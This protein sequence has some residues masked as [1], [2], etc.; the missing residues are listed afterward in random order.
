M[1]NVS[2]LLALLLAL[3]LIVGCGATTSSVENTSAEESVAA[4]PPVEETPAEEVPAEEPP[5][6]AQS[7]VEAPAPETDVPTEEPANE[8]FTPVAYSFPL[9]EESQTLTYFTTISPNNTSFM[10]NYSVNESV[11]VLEELTGVHIEY[12]CY[13]PENA[14][15]QF[16][17]QAAAGSLPDIILGATEYYSGGM[18]TAVDDDILLNLADYL[19][20]APNYSQI[21]DLTPDMRSSLSTEVGNL[22]GFY[23]YSDPAIATPVSASMMI[24][25]DWLEQVGMEAP[26]TYDELHDVLVA[27]KNEMSVEYPMIVTSYLDDMGGSFASGYDIKAFFMTS[28]GIQV[29]FY[30]IDGQVKCAIVEDAFV[31][32]IKMIQGLVAEGLVDPNVESY[33]NERSYQDKVLAGETGVFWGFGIR[34]M[35]TLNSQMD[36]Y[37][38]AVPAMRK[39][40]DQT[41]HFT[42]DA[43]YEV[44]SAVSLSANCSDIELACKWLDAH[45]TEEI[46]MMAMYGV[47]GVSY[48][49]VDGKPQYTE[50]MLNPE[51]EGMTLNTQKSL[52]CLAEADNVYYKYINTDLDNYTEDQIEALELVNS[53]NM[54]GEYVYPSGASMTTEESETYTALIADLSTYMAE[55]VLKFVVGVEPMD[56]Y[57]AFIETLYEMGMQE[58]IDIKQAAYDRYVG[59]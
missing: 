26:T 34:D 22:I 16:N 14:Q 58:A 11:K 46:S 39:T 17:L 12:N 20:Y 59:A 5:A 13:I 1:K 29:P 21:L 37:L 4:A 15:T 40:E 54:D 10:D 53:G 32:Y 31:D 23:A 44:R 42:T 9:V 3:C 56:D 33:S 38:V 35:E 19:D 51:T 25:G 49:M 30:V 7:A 47:E 2:K 18:D 27:F 24:R 48:E 8:G 43:S 28:P 36:G 50:M 55:H 41:L 45:Y 6:D 57:Q 52:F